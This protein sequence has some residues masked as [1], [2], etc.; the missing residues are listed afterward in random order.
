MCVFGQQ[1]RVP[2]EKDEKKTGKKKKRDTHK[3]THKGSRSIAYLGIPRF[4]T[5]T[6]I[7]FLMFNNIPY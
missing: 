3:R 5:Q 6:N 2:G 4:Q 7:F 1:T